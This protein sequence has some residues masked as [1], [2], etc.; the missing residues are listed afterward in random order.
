MPRTARAQA[1]T[2]IFHVINR[3]ND[4][5][6]VFH[7]DGDY[8]A[9]LCCFATTKARHPVRAFCF[10]LMPTHFHFLLHADTSAILGAFMH[11]WMTSHVRRYHAHHRTSGHLWQDRFKTFPVETD[12][13]FVTVCPQLRTSYRQR[14]WDPDQPAAG[15]SCW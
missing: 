11:R 9:F 10:C 1:N 4:R 12:N 2:Q 8:R 14:L 13:H 3:G 7:K 6:T 5:A 15:I